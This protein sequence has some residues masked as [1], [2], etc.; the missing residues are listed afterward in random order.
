M[1]VNII[2][3]CI[4]NCQNSNIVLEKQI[5]LHSYCLRIHIALKDIEDFY[6]QKKI[7]MFAHF[8]TLHNFD[9]VGHTPYILDNID[10]YNIGNDII[11]TVDNHNNV[12][13]TK[14]LRWKFIQKMARLYDDNE[15]F[16][17]QNSFRSECFCPHIWAYSLALYA[18]V[19]RIMKCQ[20]LQPDIFRHDNAG[21][22]PFLLMEYSK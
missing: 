5:L 15:F 18:Y 1:F 3:I 13:S 9:T 17:S 22:N 10:E 6:E 20:L 14:T 21:L 11:Y 8:E 4:K 19:Y 2:I 12:L 16:L 7:L